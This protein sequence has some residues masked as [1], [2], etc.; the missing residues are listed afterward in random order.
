M[1]AWKQLGCKYSDIRQ[2]FFFKAVPSLQRIL[3]I[4]LRKNLKHND[5]NKTHVL[6]VKQF[7][8]CPQSEKL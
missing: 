2:T 8:N 1:A 3:V 4:K 5:K 6:K 7:Q